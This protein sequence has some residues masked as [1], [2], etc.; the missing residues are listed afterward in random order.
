[1]NQN[2]ETISKYLLKKLIKYNRF[3]YIPFGELCIRYKMSERLNDHYEM[4]ELDNKNKL[5]D[6]N[7]EVFEISFWM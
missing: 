5:T 7:K 4:L 6:K 3:K 1:M 2:N